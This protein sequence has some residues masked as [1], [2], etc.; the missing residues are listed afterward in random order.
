[1]S[2][3]TLPGKL[4]NQSVA[5]GFDQPMEC[6]FFQL[7]DPTKDEDVPIIDV[8]TRKNYEICVLL[9]THAD[10][11]SPYAQQIRT[12]IGGDFDPEIWIEMQRKEKN[13]KADVKQMFDLVG[14][15]TLN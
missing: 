3:Y 10:L 13:V 11:S 2:R 4:L 12:G 6:Y 15:K 5:V 8:D 7:W 9:D 14:I 1:M